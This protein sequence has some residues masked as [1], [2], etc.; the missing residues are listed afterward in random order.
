MA[1][2]KTTDEIKSFL[3]VSTTFKYNDILPFIKQVERDYIIPVIGKEQY[4]DINDDYNASATPTLSDE[5]TALLAKLRVPIANF[6]FMLWIPFGQV[7]M[8][9]SGIR[10]VTTDNL[11]T[12]FQWQIDELKASSNRSG[13]SG[14][15]D[16]LEFMETNKAD[17]SLWTGSTAYTEF[18]KHFIK[19]AKEFQLHFNISSSR[20]T[21]LAMLPIMNRIEES[22]IKNTLGATKYAEIK[23]ELLAGTVSTENQDLLDI[24]IPAVA[25]LAMARA[26]NELALKIDEFGISII[27]SSQEVKAYK[28]APNPLMSDLKTQTKED[29]EYF[30]KK[31]EEK[32]NE[33]DEDFDNGPFEN[34]EDHGIVFF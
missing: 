25:N 9:S 29:G 7:Q 16:L 31:L 19:S 17:Y 22:V 14:L 27:T 3:P 6:A 18:K 1:L 8:D 30:L 20:M 33:D 23:A 24:I 32:F 12:A 28:N 10:I 21:Y 2:F 5:Q 13:Y 11:K 15:E 4:D 34:D 26:I